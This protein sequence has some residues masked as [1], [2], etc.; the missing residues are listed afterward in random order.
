MT[1][2]TRLITK[3]HMYHPVFFKG[4]LTWIT[5]IISFF[6]K[7][8]LT[9]APPKH[10]TYHPSRIICFAYCAYFLIQK[11]VKSWFSRECRSCHWK[12]FLEIGVKHL[13]NT[14]EKAHFWAMQTWDLYIY[15]YIYIYIKI[16]K[17]IYIYLNIMRIYINN[18]GI[19]Q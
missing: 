13:K 5:W 19:Q 1:T 10:Y 12:V 2:K 8:Y 6:F 17:K 9:I 16:N 11:F 3:N 14:C 4:Y 15:I 7:G 18:L